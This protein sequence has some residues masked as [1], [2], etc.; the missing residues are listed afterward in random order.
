[1]I[2]VVS[3]DARDQH[4]D[5]IDKAAEYAAFGVKW[6]WLVDPDER[7]FEIHELAGSR[8]R[9]V[10]SPHEGTIDVPGCDARE[11]FKHPYAYAQRGRFDDVLAA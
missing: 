6:Y 1:M 11:A 5:R 4:R 8:Y 3:S 7:S 9:L 10:A 2:E